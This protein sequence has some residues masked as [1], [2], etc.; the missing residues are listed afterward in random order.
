MRVS[1]KQILAVLALPICALLILILGYGQF[2]LVADRYY[3]AW[4]FDCYD[5]M[6]NAND[7]KACRW[8]LVGST[9]EGKK[10]IADTMAEMGPN[11]FVENKGSYWVAALS[12]DEAKANRYLDFYARIEAWLFYVFN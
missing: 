4:G 6:L 7:S 11:V 10:M 5:V 2:C 9:D 3:I 12:E 1:R 8:V